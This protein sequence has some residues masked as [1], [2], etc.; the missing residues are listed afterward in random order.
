[1]LP[2][3]FPQPQ[4]PKSTQGQD[5]GNNSEGEPGREGPIHPLTA[6]ARLGQVRAPRT[7]ESGPGIVSRPHRVKLL[8]LA[9]APIKRSWGRVP[10]QHPSRRSRL[11]S[12]PTLSPVLTKSRSSVSGD[13]ITSWSSSDPSEK[14]CFPTD[15]SPCSSV[16]T[17]PTRPGGT[18]TS[19]PRRLRPRKDASSPGRGRRR[20]TVTPDARPS[21]ASPGA[22]VPATSGGPRAPGALAPLLAEESPTPAR[23][24]PGAVVPPRALTVGTLAD[25]WGEEAPHRG[26]PA[27]RDLAGQ[28]V[29]RDGGGT[30]QRKR[31]QVHAAPVHRLLVA[32]LHGSA[33]PR[34]SLAKAEAGA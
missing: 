15:T 7:L 1:M 12:L 10:A 11:H 18:A 3:C 32:A 33:A 25:G 5:S 13:S 17:Y 8:K 28:K 30:A 23:G 31:A 4:S 29:Q 34:R 16:I 6:A 24:L 19:S 9:V 20:A 27:N 2:Q 14:S 22:A 26:G 21:G